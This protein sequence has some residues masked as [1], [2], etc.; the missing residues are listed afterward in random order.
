MARPIKKGLMYFPFDVDFFSDKK[1]KALK[2]RYNGDGVMF[3]LYML[4]EIYREG[5]YIR[6]DED[7]EDNAMND[8]NLSEGFIKQVMAFFFSRSLL[9]SILV[10]EDTVITSP[11]IQRRYQEACKGLKRQ[12][13]VNCEIWLL[14]TDETASFIKLTHNED[15]SNK[16]SRLPEK[17]YSLSEKNH[18]K[19]MK[20]NETKLHD[21]KE[22]DNNNAVD[23]SAIFKKNFGYSPTDAEKERL[24]L[25]LSQ[26]DSEIVEYALFQA[27]EKNKKTLAYAM[28]VLKNLAKEGV[29]NMEQL[30]EYHMR[31]GKF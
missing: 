31:T 9:T 16:N 12:I 1:I 30:A 27:V 25:L 2:V 26:N 21:T 18:T 13:D 14:G 6:W 22:N 7:S 24:S 29:T 10:N 5:Y 3:Y 4:T 23:G 8:L 28:G 19:E 20:G 17:N 15:K 11:A